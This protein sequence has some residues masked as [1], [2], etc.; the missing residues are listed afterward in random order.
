MKQQRAPMESIMATHPLELVQI[1]YLCLEPGKGK[2]ENVLVVMVHFTYYAQAYVTQ[3]QMALS[4]AKTL[5][6]NLIIHYRLMEKIVLDQGRNFDS[7]LIADLCKLM[8]TKKHRTSLH[9]PQTND[10]SKRFNSTLINMLGT[11]PPECKSDW[12]SSIGVLVH[13]YNCT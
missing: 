11:L 9:H 12:K 1:N 5:W 10:Q 3:F 2:E 7:G 4:M 8:G 13:A 6:D